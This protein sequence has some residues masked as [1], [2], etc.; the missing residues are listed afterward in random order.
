MATEIRAFQAGDEDRVL[1]LHRE[2]FP[3]HPVR[4]RAHLDWKF[5]RNPAGPPEAMLALQG[6]RCVAFYGCLPIRCMLQGE[7]VVLGLQ[8]DIAVA[9][10]L[11]RG[12]AGSRLLIA[13][14]QEYTRRFVAGRKALEW[15]FPQPELQRVGERFLRIRALRDVSWIVKAAGRDSPRFGEIAVSEGDAIPD[16]IDEFWHRVGAGYAL[17][18]IRDECYLA[19][20]YCQH[21]DVR[22][23]VFEARSAGDLRG[24]AI[25]R[26]GGPDPRLLTLMEWM[27]APGDLEAEH[28]LLARLTDA[29]RARGLAYLGIWIPLAFPLARHLQ[30]RHGFFAHGSPFLECHRVWRSGLT[31]HWLAENWFQTTGDF[32]FF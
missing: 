11:R 1:A 30:E 25:V 21:P 22:Y 3:D 19:W 29:A 8:T 2:A 10:D 15:G 20:R 12:L 4:G 32:D 16:G 14:C 24:V 13:T 5:H 6:E 26:D 17:A 23:T 18:T 28:A 7:P 27:T 31:R 9:P